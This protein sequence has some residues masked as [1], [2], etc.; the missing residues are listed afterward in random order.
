M[1]KGRYFNIESDPTYRKI[2]RE[3]LDTLDR[4]SDYGDF[5]IDDVYNKKRPL[6]DLTIDSL[7]F[8]NFMNLYNQESKIITY[9]GIKSLA[10]SEGYGFGMPK[11]RRGK[12]DKTMNEYK[13]MYKINEDVKKELKNLADNMPYIHL[14]N[15]HETSAEFYKYTDEIIKL[16]DKLMED[17]AFKE[18]AETY[19]DD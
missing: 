11:A 10:R 9:D 15:S 8:V 6:L 3:L 13:T 18:L 17:P 7:N 4:L 1:E 12:L 14:L 19:K 5:F 16:E 2:K